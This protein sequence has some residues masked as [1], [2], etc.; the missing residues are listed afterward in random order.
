M[1]S[2]V[3]GLGVVGQ[4][5]KNGINDVTYLYDKTKTSENIGEPNDADVI[6]I[7]LPTPTDKTLRQDLNPIQDNLD[8][9][10]D[11]EFKGII[12]IKSTVLPGTCKMLNTIYKKLRIVHNP[13]FLTA[14]NAKADFLQQK[15]LLL[16]G[17]RS[18][19]DLIEEYFRGKSKCPMIKD[20]YKSEDYQ[21]TEWAKY[22]HN[23]TLAVKLSFLN[24]IYQ[25]IGEDGVYEKATEMAYPFGNLGDNHQVPGPDGMLGYGG[26]CFPKDM[27]A[28]AGYMLDIS[29]TLKGALLTNQ[30]VRGS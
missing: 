21:V 2:G 19:V 11:Q 9:L 28:L 26:E 1:K 13:E 4:A 15:T 23:C 29:N 6:F 24:E 3:I 12:V 17:E 20:V 18:D 30:R 8:Y 7:C 27:K 5:V 22:I 25:A 16:S 14:S 10:Q